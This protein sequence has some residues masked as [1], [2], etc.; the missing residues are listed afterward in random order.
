M[1]KIYLITNQINGKQYVGQ[2][3]FSLQQ[4]F[5]RHCQDALKETLKNRPLY[6]AMRK[7]GIDNFIITL[8]EE[9]DS[10]D[11]REQYWIKELQTYISGYNATLG[12]E[13]KT[14]YPHNEILQ[15]LKEHPYPVD[16]AKEFHCHKDTIYKIAQANNIQVRNKS[17]E[18]LAERAKVISQYD[19]TGQWLQDFNSTQEAA[20]WCYNNG[21]CA[22]LNSGVRSHISE[23][24]NGKRKTA[25]KHMWK[26]N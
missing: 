1:A 20:I 23:C 8:I 5:K 17:Q 18:H 13:G 14:L 6:S 10:P 12:G 16:I 4:R 21:L 9:T 24:A 25:Y 2:T 11:E 19:L 26:Y 15:R 3:S 22:T 7:Y